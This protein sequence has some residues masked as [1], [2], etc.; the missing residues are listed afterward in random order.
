MYGVGK[1]A[2]EDIIPIPNRLNNR[3]RNFLG[4]KIRDEVYDAMRLAA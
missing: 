1:V 3:L 2:D 4:Y